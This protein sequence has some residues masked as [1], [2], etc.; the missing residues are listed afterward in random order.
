MLLLHTEQSNA[1]C[2]MVAFVIIM[3]IFFFLFLA[4]TA[5]YQEMIA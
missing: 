3:D 2:F 4:V 5:L 1:Q